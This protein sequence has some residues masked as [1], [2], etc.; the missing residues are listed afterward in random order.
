MNGT[1]LDGAHLAAMH[2]SGHGSVT[3]VVATPDE[4]RVDVV[5]LEL[6]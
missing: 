6:D 2:R 3:F 4:H 5:L 1:Q